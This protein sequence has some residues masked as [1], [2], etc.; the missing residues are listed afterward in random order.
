MITVV[1]RTLITPYTRSS[2]CLGYTPTRSQTGRHSCAHFRP[3]DRTRD[4]RHTDFVI[5]LIRATYTSDERS[6]PLVYTHIQRH[7]KVSIIG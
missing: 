4:N 3:S 1:I 6:V 7:E 5:A 2:D